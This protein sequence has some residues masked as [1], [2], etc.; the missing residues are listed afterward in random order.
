MNGFQCENCD[1]NTANSGE[2]QVVC[3]QVFRSYQITGV[4]MRFV[5]GPA[6]FLQLPHS[7][8]GADEKYNAPNRETLPT[9]DAP[10]FHGDTVPEKCSIRTLRD[11]G[12]WPKSMLPSSKSL[13]QH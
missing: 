1:E 12:Y 4:A 5:A 3:G 11:G 7:D 8:R 13:F 10:P 2:H 6:A 9:R